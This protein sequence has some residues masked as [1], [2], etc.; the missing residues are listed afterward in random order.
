MTAGTPFPAGSSRVG[1]TRVL[2]VARREPAACEV[3][4]LWLEPVDDPPLPGWEPGAHLDLLLPGNLVRQYSLC[5][6]PGDGSVWQ[7][8]VQLPPD[9]G[10]GGSRTVFEQLH[11]GRE[12]TVRGPRNAFAL[13]P[14]PRYLFVAGGIGITPLLAMVDRAQQDG[15]D[16]QLVYGGRTRA[17]MPFLQRLAEYGERVRV[18]PQDEVGLLPLPEL[19]RTPQP[20]TLVYCCGPLPL[21]DALE[22]AM[23]QAGWPR[24]SL[25][26]ERFASGT[27]TGPLPGDDARPAGSFRSRKGAEPTSETEWTFEV[28]LAGNGQLITIGPDVSVLEALE[29]AGVSV[30]SSCRKGICGSCEVDVLAGTIDHRDQ[31]LTPEEQAAN[32]TML[33]C[34]SRSVGPRLL[35]DL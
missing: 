5:G 13:R 2:R 35:L 15:A 8:A 32:D 17:G 18:A 29:Q 10:R 27:P 33:I 1:Q 21:I 23:A 12:V 9:G 11:P 7:V 3:V 20:D 22:A 14:S 16:W 30:M 25:V 24:Q 26:V 6:D 31:L 19:V 28:E 34:V 4:A